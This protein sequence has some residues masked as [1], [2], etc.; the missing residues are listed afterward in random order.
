MTGDEVAIERPA[1]VSVGDLENGAARLVSFSGEIDLGT[2][3]E[4]GDVVS[5]ETADALAVVLDLTGVTFL[6]SAGVRL[7][8][9][10]VGA[11]ESRGCVMKLVA[12]E[13]GVARF[14]LTLCAFR[15][16]LLE[17]TVAR[18]VASLN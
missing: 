1:A 5:Q 2:A 14:T 9:T 15:S 17:S 6:D 3:P 18:A 13:H 7:L 12:P 8:D 11:A 10:L 4:L 16:D